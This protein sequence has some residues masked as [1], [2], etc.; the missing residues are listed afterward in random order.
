[1][2]LLSSVLC[3]SVASARKHTKKLTSLGIFNI[4][5]PTRFNYSLIEGAELPFQIA[6]AH[7]NP[8]V[9]QDASKDLL[10][11]LY[12]RIIGIVAAR[13]SQPLAIKLT[14]YS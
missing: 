3:L 11:L 8:W 7:F 12:V 9:L 5:L 10:N 13:M 6:L 2:A 4:K 1:M 14:T